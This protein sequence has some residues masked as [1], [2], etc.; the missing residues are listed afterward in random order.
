MTNLTKPLQFPLA[1]EMVGGEPRVFVTPQKLADFAQSEHEAWVRASKS[2][3]AIAK[4]FPAIESLTKVLTARLVDGPLELKRCAVEFA[5]S[6]TGQTEDELIRALTH[7]AGDH[8]AL[9]PIAQS[10]LGERMVSALAAQPEEALAAL[11]VTTKLIDD[12]SV[13]LDSKERNRL[14][15][16]GLG[17]LHEFDSFWADD[18]TSIFP[19][20]ISIN[21]EPPQ[22]FETVDGAIAWG[23]AEVQFW[24]Q[25]GAAFPRHSNFSDVVATRLISPGETFV[26]VIELVTPPVVDREKLPTLYATLREYAAGNAISSTSHVAGLIKSLVEQKEALTALA[27]AFI[28]TGEE[29]PSARRL[30]PRILR[31]LIDAR[32]QIDTISF[33][34]RTKKFDSELTRLNAIVDTVTSRVPEL[35]TQVDGIEQRN[36]ALQKRLETQEAKADLEDPVKHWHEKTEEHFQRAAMF[37]LIAVGITVIFAA[38]DLNQARNWLDDSRLLF[39]SYKNANFEQSKYEIVIWPILS[40]MV[41][42]GAQ[43]WILRL[44]IRLVWDNHVLASDAEERRYMVQSLLSLAAQPTFAAKV[45]DHLLPIALGVLFRQTAHTATSEAAPK[46]AA[47]PSVQNISFSAPSDQVGSKP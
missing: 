25:I 18:I 31:A 42:I 38:F 28:A 2:F 16:L 22:T 12:P 15:N 17:F 35:L 32:A 14:R 19:L 46:P 39:E 30:S 21:G 41:V 36:K 27:V 7:F 8:D 9:A 24:S 1:L 43:Y 26:R 29:F 10:T 34:Q 3:P 20:T 6:R 44:L 13:M 11:A 23:R 33:A 45:N 47:T 5:K 37:A 4:S 40:A